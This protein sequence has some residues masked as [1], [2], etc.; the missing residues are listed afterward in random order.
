MGGGPQ[1]G[2]W[3]WSPTVCA[4][5]WSQSDFRKV[6]GPSSGGYGLIVRDQ[7][8]PPLDGLRQNGRF[9]VLEA[10]DRGEIGIWRRD[11]DQWVDLLAWSKGACPLPSMLTRSH[12]C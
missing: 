12:N 4:T 8:V 10:S 2:R 7:T 3:L 9:Y 6:G 1:T 5:W 11:D